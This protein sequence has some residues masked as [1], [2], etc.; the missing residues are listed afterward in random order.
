MKRKYEV[1]QKVKIIQDIDN[2]R[3]IGDPGITE[4]MYA[5]QGSDT[6]IYRVL[7]FDGVTH[8]YAVCN[9]R[10]TWAEKWLE[11]NE[12]EFELKTD[13]ILCLLKG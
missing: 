1:G 5:Y 2:H 7:P 4:E 13:D 9:N 10:W 11:S 3:F 12:P 6:E 8:R